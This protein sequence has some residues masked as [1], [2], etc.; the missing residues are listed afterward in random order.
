[1][2]CC[3]FCALSSATRALL[4][5]AKIPI[6]SPPLSLLRTMQAKIHIWKVISA[7]PAAAFV[8]DRLLI[9]KESL[10]FERNREDKLIFDVPFKGK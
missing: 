5:F 2:S 10:R 3:S 9:F 6:H 7:Q 4:L 8:A 1:M